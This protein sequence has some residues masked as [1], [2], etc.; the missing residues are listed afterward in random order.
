MEQ[1]QRKYAQTIIVLNSFLFCFRKIIIIVTTI[2][3]VYIQRMFYLTFGI[4]SLG[5]DRNQS[6]EGCC[7]VFALCQV[8][9]DQILV[10]AEVAL[11]SVFFL[12]WQYI[13]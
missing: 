3:A 5:N 11:A 13:L 2:V 8:R 1:Y 12:C 6:L 4:F 10:M 7:Q 9:Q